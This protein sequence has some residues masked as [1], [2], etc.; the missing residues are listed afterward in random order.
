MLKQDKLTGDSTVS[1]KVVS[2]EASKWKFK[3]VDGTV[4][5]CVNSECSGEVK[6]WHVRHDVTSHI[7][8]ACRHGLVVQLLMRNWCVPCLLKVNG[9]G[10][11]MVV[12]GDSG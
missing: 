6:Q 5:K 11:R 4:K 9:K 2:G 12:E 8:Y 10:I 7:N 3:K 1:I